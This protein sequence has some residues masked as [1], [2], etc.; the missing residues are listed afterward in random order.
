VSGEPTSPAES[1]RSPSSTGSVL[2]SAVLFVVFATAFIQAGSYSPDAALFPR[3]ISAVA[4]V[5]AALTF[6]Q[7]VRRPAAR[8]SELKTGTIRWRDH[9]I[10]YAGP[11][12]YVG[13]MV[14]LG[15][16]IASAIFLAGLLVMLGTRNPLI[17]SLI[18]TGTLILIYVA[19][20]LTFSIPLPASLLF[21]FGAS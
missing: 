10:S 5:C 11:P 18:T 1:A 12:L 19:F 17:V 20:E 14:L 7:S 8:V 16:W 6:A 15:F 21:D 3:L 2:F 13:L 9:L 4:M